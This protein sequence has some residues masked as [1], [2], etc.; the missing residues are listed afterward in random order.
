[1][2]IIGRN[3][4]YI[5]QNDKYTIL[6]PLKLAKVKNI[7]Y[8]SNG[9][10]EYMLIR[11]ITMMFNFAP[12]GRFVVFVLAIVVIVG[13]AILGLLAILVE[14]LCILI[15]AYLALCIVSWTIRWIWTGK[16]PFKFK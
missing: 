7:L 5:G 2:N 6:G 1:M 13:C 12:L 3:R 15:V 8:I 10:I 14:Y 16:S 9:L 4:K 11:N